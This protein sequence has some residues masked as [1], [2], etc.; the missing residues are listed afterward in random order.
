MLQLGHEVWSKVSSCEPTSK[1]LYHRASF[2]YS[3]IQLCSCWQSCDIVYIIIC[4][5]YNYILEAK[6][7]NWSG[8][9]SYIIPI[10]STVTCCYTN[11]GAV[12]IH[13]MSCPT[14]HICHSVLPL[15][16]LYVRTYWQP[17]KKKER[18]GP[19]PF[20]GG[21]GFVSQSMHFERVWV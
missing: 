18:F 13:R 2:V 14:S 8:I 1:G 6:C 12:A 16:L 7:C 21:Q 15:N 10:A 5:P 4:T 20:P 9:H 3:S 17:V 11:T 19:G